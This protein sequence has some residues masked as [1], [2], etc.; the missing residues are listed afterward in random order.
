MAKVK[1]GFSGL[2][3]PEQVERARLIVTKMTG[4][5]IY[6]T[7]SPELA[8]VTAA[9]NALETAFNQSRSRDKDKIIAK[10]L[11]R[12]EVLFLVNQLGAYVQEASDGD[13]E[14]IISSGFD[15]RGANTPHSD[16]AGA[17]GNVRLSDGSNHG[18]IR[19][20]FDAAEN[21]VLYSIVAGIDVNAM[22]EQYKGISS[23][24]HK[25]FGEFSPG[26]NVW[27]SIIPLG[28]EN[29]GP[30]TEPVHIIVR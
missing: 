14:K 28:R 8:E 3:V 26:T 19:V 12:K 24:T 27:V 25:E 17:A 22:V 9:A 10:N 21:A 1:I 18:R 30:K 13:T 7:P 2:S 6:T 16:T 4:N 11:R 15:V 20:D 29:P 23:K 5:G